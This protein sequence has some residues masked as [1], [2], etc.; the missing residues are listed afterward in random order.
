MQ[1]AVIVSAVRT[2][3]GKAPRGSLRT[4]RPDD[5]AAVVMKA[6]IERAGVDASEIE[7]V[8]L[9]C[10]FPE[11]EQG[12]NVARIA[13]LRAGFP[14]SVCGQTTNRFCSSGLQTIASAA[15]QIM[16]GMGESIIAGGVESL[17]TAPWRISASPGAGS[18][19][20]TSSQRI[21]SGPPVAWIRMALVMGWSVS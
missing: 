12:M 9:G 1:N 16:A 6:V 2:A 10:A 3:V 17:S 20:G 15:Q 11:A 14:E 7:D 13:S 19:V 8:N 21:T 18:G 5:M 4:M